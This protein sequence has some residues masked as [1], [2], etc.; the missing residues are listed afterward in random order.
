MIK[1][2]QLR[3]KSVKELVTFFLALNGVSMEFK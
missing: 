2:L 1:I 3:V